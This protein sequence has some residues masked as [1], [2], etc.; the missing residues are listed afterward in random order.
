MKWYDET[1][2]FNHEPIDWSMRRSPWYRNYH[3]MEELK[4]MWNTRMA[5]IIEERENV[6]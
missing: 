2:A 6:K 1:R 4:E 3:T 5:Q